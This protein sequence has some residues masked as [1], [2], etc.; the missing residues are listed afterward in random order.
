MRH[1]KF[2]Q[3]QRLAKII[4]PKWLRRYPHASCSGRLRAN[5]CGN[6]TKIYRETFI[7]RTPSPFA[8]RSPGTLAA[9]RRWLINGGS[10][11]SKTCH[12]QDIGLPCLRR[13]PSS[14]PQVSLSLSRVA[15]RA[16]AARAAARLA[17]ARARQDRVRSAAPARTARPRRRAV[18]IQAL[19]IR[20]RSIRAHR[21]R[22][23]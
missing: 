22:V 17:P 16:V 1:E 14:A 2:Q 19:Q 10:D 7:A 6:V 9:A 3:R 12:G 13:L 15:V 20:A 23:R 11:R 21:T 8:R 18:P 5:P 4:R